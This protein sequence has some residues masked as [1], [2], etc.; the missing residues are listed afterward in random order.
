MDGSL[1]IAPAYSLVRSL[2]GAG[3]AVLRPVACGSDCR[4]AR[5]GSRMPKAPRSG[6]SLTP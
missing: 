2:F 3:S 6:V 1:P 5:K 4:S